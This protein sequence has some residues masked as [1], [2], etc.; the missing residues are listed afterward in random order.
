MP[1]F[2]WELVET[3]APSADS[4][5]LPWILSGDDKEKVAKARSLVEEAL[6]T[7]SKPSA[8]GYLILADP[9]SY[10]L[11]IGTGGRTINGI[12]DQTGCDIQVPKAGWSDEG[13]AITIVGAKDACEQA[14]TL[15][16]EAVQQN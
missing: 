16:L 6:A 2:S 7:A 1:D 10:R 12:R 11:V 15:I 3:D 13:E 4:D 8:T 14:K 5:S 9:R